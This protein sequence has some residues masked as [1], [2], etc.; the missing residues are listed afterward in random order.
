MV[1]LG[2]E[3]AVRGMI[4]IAALILERVRRGCRKGIHCVL[5]AP[6]V[7]SFLLT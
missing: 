1:P 3:R 6:M 4:K 5:W 2:E 7:K